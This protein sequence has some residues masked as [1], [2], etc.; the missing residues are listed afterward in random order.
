MRELGPA[1]AGGAVL[2]GGVDE[3]DGANGRVKR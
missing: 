2:R 1:P 3:E